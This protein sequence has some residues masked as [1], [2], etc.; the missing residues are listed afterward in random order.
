MGLAFGGLTILLIGLFLGIL[1][2]AATVNRAVFASGTDLALSRLQQA[3]LIYGLFLTSYFII[4]GWVAVGRITQP[5]TEMAAAARRIYQGER[6]LVIPTIAGEDEVAILSRSLN[7]LVG[8]MEGQRAALEVAKAELEVRVNERTRKL[9][10]LYEVVQRA[11]NEN[12]LGAVVRAS[13]ARALAGT[14]GRA[15]VVYLLD[16]YG[17]RLQWVGQ[18]GENRGLPAEG[19]PGEVAAD[20]P[21]FQ[22]LLALPRPLLIGETAA[23]PRTAG[24][25]DGA[26]Y[27]VCLAVPIHTTNQTWG[28]LAVL[29]QAVT[30]FGEEEQDLWGSVANQLGIAVE[31]FHLRQQAEQLA[32]MEERNRLARELH[33]SVT[34]SLYSAVLFVEASRRMIEAGKAEKAAGYLTD[35]GET[36]QQALKEMRLLVHKLRPSALEREGLLF[37]LEQRLKAVEARVGIQYQLTAEGTLR[38]TPDLE[39]SLYHIAQEGLNN[40]LRHARASQVAVHFQQQEGEVALWVRDN[41][42]GFD[43]AAAGTGGGLGLT[44]MREWAAMFEGTVTVESTPA[45]GTVVTARLKSPA[46]GERS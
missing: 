29:G 21:L 12:D 20:H 15:G 25:L 23:D 44:T 28:L 36:S 40:A 43:V 33:D 9:S 35:V 13:L 45:E 16:K 7:Q 2:L 5:I 22:A 14:A 34:Q 10:I 17:Q 31:R 26:G 8:E 41:G 11:G 6:S 30:Q 1:E 24:L 39:E 19:L 4:L 42:K 18:E 3:I 32:V 37:A 27:A 38:L 46:T